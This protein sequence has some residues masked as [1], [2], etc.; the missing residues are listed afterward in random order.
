MFPQANYFFTLSGHAGLFN[1]GNNVPKIAFPKL[2]I[3]AAQTC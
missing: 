1:I 2:L 3:L